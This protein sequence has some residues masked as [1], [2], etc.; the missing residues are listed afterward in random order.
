MWE[1]QEI[2]SLTADRDR[3]L[4]LMGIEKDETAEGDKAQE[5]ADA[6]D[7]M[8]LDEDYFPLPVVQDDP[9]LKEIYE[10]QKTLTI[11][12]TNFLEKEEWT[13]LLTNIRDFRVLKMPHILQGLFFL[14]KFERE[15]ICEV[16]SNKFS[17]KKAKQL[18]VTE[19][20]ERMKEYKVWDAK[21]DEYR[22]YMRLNYVEN[23]IAPLVQEDVTAYHEGMGKL[24]KWLKMAV[25]TR[26]LDI[27]RRKATQKRNREEKTS[28]EE[29]KEKRAA[30][31]EQFLID[32][33]NEFNEANKEDIDAYRA[34]EEE[35]NRLAEQEYGEEKGSEDEDADNQ[36]EPP[37]L[38]EFDKKE[39]EEKFD[40]ENPEVE[41]PPDAEDDI[42]N[43][44]L[45]DEDEALAEIE[46]FNNGGANKAD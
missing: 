33:E 28:R 41:I 39:M 1:A 8:E 3:K 37:V 7:G 35:Q 20:P 16:N 46:K 36:K 6:I 23:L 17:W 43:D 2:A 24:F 34:W 44:W 26:K 22:P 12:A 30:D 5:L 19:L 32:K 42:N 40:E 45:L 4:E 25:T 31:R 10:A 14:T 27:I 29:A 15:K 38:P 21:T 18:L 13:N 9:T 11:E